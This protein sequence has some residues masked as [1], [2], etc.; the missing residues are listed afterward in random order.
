M[1]G[2]TRDLPTLSELAATIARSVDAST[3]VLSQGEYPAIALALGGRHLLLMR[4]HGH[5]V[6]LSLPTKH[7]WSVRTRDELAVEQPRIVEQLTAYRAQYPNAVSMADAFVALEP[8]LARIAPPWKLSFPGTPIP[9]ECWLASSDGRSVGLFQNE[10]SQFAQPSARVV[11][12]LGDQ[13]K[14]SSATNPRALA[15]LGPW[16]EPMLAEQTKALAA[17]AVAE[18]TKQARPLPRLE[19]V[20][21]LLRSGKRMSS[22]GGRYSQTYFMEGDVLRC[23]IFDEGHREVVDATVEELG[24]SIDADFRVV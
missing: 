6:S 14:S 15:Q 8:T 21:A 7:H 18:Q 19:D 9:S 4:D 24:K 22:G 17:A 11:V 23:D 2:Q 12:W 3:S 16:I 5:G 13:M 10:G 1:T 20:L